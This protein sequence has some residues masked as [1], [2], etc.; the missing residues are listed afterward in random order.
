MRQWFDMLQQSSASSIVS[1]EMAQFIDKGIDRL[2]EILERNRVDHRTAPPPRTRV[3]PSITLDN[4][5]ILYV[6][7]GTERP[8]G[9]RH[10]NDFVNI[11]DIAIAPTHEELTTLEPPYLPYNI[12]NAPHSFPNGSMQRLLD[13][14]FRLLREELMYVPSSTSFFH[15]LIIIL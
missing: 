7:P 9:P 13:I 8:E 3:R 5:R 14:N 6:G 15:E 2:L 10:D 4:L 1:H 12:P 11:Q